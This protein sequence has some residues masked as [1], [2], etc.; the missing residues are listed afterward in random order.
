MNDNPAATST[1]T[2]WPGYTPEDLAWFAAHY[3][4]TEWAVHVIGPDDVHVN[5]PDAQGEHNPDGKPLT[6]Q[7]A[8]ALADQVHR[9]NAWYRAK[10]G[11][12]PA[13]T[14]DLIPNV[15]HRGVLVAGAPPTPA[16]T[17][18]S[19]SGLVVSAF[20]GA[21]DCEPCQGTGLNIGQPGD[22]PACGGTGG[23]R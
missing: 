4:D 2:A 13:Y 9:F 21:G 8:W 3:A 1:P 10:F 17:G 5:E 20:R 15:F 14:Q 23:V 22:C 12:K 18:G 16:S 19:A 6:E 11:E 7:T